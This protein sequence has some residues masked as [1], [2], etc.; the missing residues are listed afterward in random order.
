LE[1]AF[2]VKNTA[3][4]PGSREDNLPDLYRIP[5]SM[6]WPQGVASLREQLVGLWTYHISGGEKGRDVIAELQPRTAH[7][8]PGVSLAGVEPRPG[9]ASPTRKDFFFL[10][11]ADGKTYDISEMS[12]GEQAVFEILFEFVRLRIAKSVVLIDE[13]ELHLHPPQQQAL[14]PALPKLGHDCQFIITTHS[15]YV[16][17]ALPEEEIVR[18]EG[19]EVRP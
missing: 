3:P 5:E 11:R 12:S 15:R 6:S 10:L 19:G 2:H 13:L 7:V 8:F 16:E 17:D 9:A 1:R 14:L 4:P 18:L